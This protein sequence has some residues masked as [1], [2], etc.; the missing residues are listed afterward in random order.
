MLLHHLQ[1]PTPASHVRHFAATAP[2]S[3]QLL[4]DEDSRVGRKIVYQE[5]GKLAV[6]CNT[7][8]DVMKDKKQVGG[9]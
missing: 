6:T 4:S 8:D 5:L 7:G 3:L 9:G 2:P 1:E